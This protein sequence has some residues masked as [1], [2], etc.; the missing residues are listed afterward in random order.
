MKSIIKQK[1]A[2]TLIELLVVIAI[3]AILAA[4][5]LPALAA[6]KRKAQRI[7]CINNLKQDTLAFKMFAGDNSDKYPMA[8]GSISTQ[9]L[10]G[11]GNLAYLFNTMTNELSTP[12]I[13]Y[14]PSDTVNY[15]SVT[16]IWPIPSAN[17]NYI[18]YFVCVNGSGEP[19]PQVILLGDHNVGAAPSLGAVA[20]N[21]FP[22]GSIQTYNNSTWSWDANN[23]HQKAGNISLCD[24]S[25]AQCSIGTFQ[26]ALVNSTN[27]AIANP[28]FSFPAY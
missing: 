11:A 26:A 1:K 2:F 7:N 14:C 9:N 16:N 15:H 28:V 17:N 23:V 25:A 12:K 24:G 19:Y 10:Q 21:D 13:L 22:S 6:A 3:I 5:L 8:V 20:P 4:M 27:G 18:S